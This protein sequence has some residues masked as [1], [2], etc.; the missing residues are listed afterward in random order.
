[1]I[2]AIVYILWCVY[3]IKRSESLIVLVRQEERE[4][5]LA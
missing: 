3:G 1:M 2:F 4:W 5:S